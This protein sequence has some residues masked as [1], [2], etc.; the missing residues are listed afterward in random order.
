MAFLAYSSRQERAR[1]QDASDLELIEA[2]QED[3]EL[4]LD[5]LIQR[6]AAPLVSLVTRIVGDSE[7]A[8]DIVQVSFLRV[9]EHRQRF[10]RRW[11]PNTWIY[12]IATNLAIDHRRSKQTRERAVH[13]GGGLLRRVDDL[14]QRALMDLEEGE[15]ST[16]FNRIAESLS[17]KQRMVFLL[18]GVEGMSS[19]EVGEVLGCR[20]STVRNHLLAARRKLRQELARLFPE[21]ARGHQ[22]ERRS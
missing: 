15:I 16:I 18:R 4:A 13:P 12:R 10:N 8:R 19:R 9:W 1:F 11:S 21:Y 7:E 2:I 14:P 20:A 22:G 3:N 5:E 6:K 17:E